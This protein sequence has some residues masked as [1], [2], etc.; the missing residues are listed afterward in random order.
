MFRLL[1][2]ACL[3]TVIGIAHAEDMVLIYGLCTE[4]PEHERSAIYP[5]TN[6][7]RIRHFVVEQQHVARLD[8]R[9]WARRER[10]RLLLPVSYVT[11]PQI[12][13]LSSQDSIGYSSSPLSRISSLKLLEAGHTAMS[14]PS[15]LCEQTGR[16]RWFLCAARRRG[17]REQPNAGRVA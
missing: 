10:E 7:S 9:W 11:E 2:N 8:A 17:P 3:S 13:Y 5:Q 12:L 16:C 4:L 1:R 15:Y 6:S 14:P